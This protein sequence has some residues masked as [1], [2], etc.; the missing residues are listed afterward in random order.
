MALSLIEVEVIAALE[1]ARLV[2]WLKKLIKDLEKRDNNN[3]PFIFTLYY[4]NKDS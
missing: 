1:G 4:N 2:V 3:K